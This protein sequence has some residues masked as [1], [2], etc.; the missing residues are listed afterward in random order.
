MAAST[1]AR[2]N[3]PEITVS[4]LSAASSGRWRRLS[5]MCGCAARF[6]AIADRIRSGHVYF[7]LKDESARIEA[8]DL[9]GHLRAAALQAGRGAGSDRDRQGHDLPGQISKYQIV[10]D[11]LEPAGVGALMALL[12][13]RKKKLAAEGLF[14][15]ARKKAA[16]VSAA[17]DRRHYVADRRGDPRHSASARR[18]LSA[19]RAG[20]ARAGAGR[21]LRCRSRGRDRRL[22]RARSR[23]A[24]SRGPMC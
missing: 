10:I 16:A 21:D 14:D 18:P 24:R 3:L 8:D 11:S 23:T 12:E 5:P 4:E 9:E 19:P 2:T 7:S 22:Q 13:E 1:E 17:R 15:E 20:L 6:P